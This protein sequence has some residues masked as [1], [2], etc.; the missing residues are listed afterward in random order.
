[1][2]TLKRGSKGDDVKL[3]QAK[4]GLKADGGFGKDTEKALIAWQTANGINPA[5]GIADQATLIKIGLVK[6]PAPVVVVPPPVIAAA[7]TA[8]NLKALKGAIPD[9]VIAQI[10]DIATK[11]NITTNLRLAHF[12]AQCAVESGTFKK[13]EENLKYSAARLLAVFPKKFTPE[14]AK[15]YGGNPEK[16]GNRVY[17][18][19]IGNGNEASGDGYRYR[20]RGY[21]QLTGK[22]NYRAFSNFIGEDCVANA[23]WVA[24]KYPL[25]SAAHY[26]NGNKIWTT[27]DKGSNAAAIKAVTLKVNKA[28]LGLQERTEFFN[29]FFALLSKTA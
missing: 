24:T 18:N 1:M 27:C 17:A 7:P 13:V 26:F 20:G 4:L 14:Q 10:A 8:L 15:E 25:A 16:I 23:D 21:I 5:N 22:D 2:D 3:L 29:K 19:I 12:L 6:A 9:N 11:F 28:A